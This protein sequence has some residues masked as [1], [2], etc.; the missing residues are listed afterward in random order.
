MVREASLMYR[1]GLEYSKEP[2]LARPRLYGTDTEWLTNH[3]LP[4]FDAPC[5]QDTAISN[6]G[7]L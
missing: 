4:F 2:Q 1:T 7:W 3:V 6:G 5:D